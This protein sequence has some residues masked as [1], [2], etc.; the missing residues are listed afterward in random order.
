[1]MIFTMSLRNSVRRGQFQRYEEKNDAVSTFV[2]FFPTCASSWSKRHFYANSR[3]FKL[4]LCLITLY[5]W[6]F[7]ASG[8]KDLGEA[9]IKCTVLDFMPLLFCR[10]PSQVVAFYC[11]Y[12]VYI[13]KILKEIEKW[14]SKGQCVI[15][16][17]PIRA[18]YTPDRQHQ[19]VFSVH[20]EIII[21]TIQTPN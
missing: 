1:M 2:L 21:F 13:T 15:L 16:I 10:S 14:E 11:Q 5:F 12:C 9:V 17:L 7:Y 8:G 19:G 6:C 3:Q 20:L 18:L 4:I